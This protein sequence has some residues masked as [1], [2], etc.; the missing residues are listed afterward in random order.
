MTQTGFSSRKECLE[1]LAQQKGFKS[2]KEY[3]KYLEQKK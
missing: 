2:H 3:K 1:H